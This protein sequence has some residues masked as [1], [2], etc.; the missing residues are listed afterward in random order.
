MAAKL[1][2]L[3]HKIAIQLHLVAESCTI[4]SSHSR[5]SVWKLLDTPSY[6]SRWVLTILTFLLS[7]TPWRRIRRVEVQLHAFFD[8]GTRWRWLVS[9]KP[10]PLWSQGKSLRYPLDRRLGGPQ[11]RS[12]QR[13]EEKNSQLPPRIELRS[14]DRPSR[15]QSLYRLG[16]PGSLNI[17]VHTGQDF[18]FVPDDTM[19]GIWNRD[20][21]A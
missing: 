8:L 19:I 5:R 10:R 13:V 15:S 3:T 2:R 20:P 1:T 14:S 21:R 17:R 6:V 7:T 9:F 12:G 16:Y 4:F 11:S 18:R